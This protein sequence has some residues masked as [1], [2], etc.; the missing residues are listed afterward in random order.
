MSTS[1]DVPIRRCINIATNILISEVTLVSRDISGVSTDKLV[2][3][4]SRK[5]EFRV[6][7]HGP[8]RPLMKLIESSSLVSRGKGCKPFSIE[9]L[10]ESVRQIQVQKMTY[11]F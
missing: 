5:E 3:K 7:A 10:N 4:L 2:P 9:K 6:L 1:C 8:L 11:R